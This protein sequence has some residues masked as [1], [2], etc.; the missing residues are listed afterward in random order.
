MSEILILI[1]PFLFSLFIYLILKGETMSK[2]IEEA[3]R[4]IH[5]L[6]HK[7]LY[8][9]DIKRNEAWEEFEKYGVYLDTL[10]HYE[11]TI[12][13]VG[14]AIFNLT[15]YLL[16]KTNETEEDNNEEENEERII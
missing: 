5:A 3:I 9:D 8:G 16:S 13:A 1:I 15:S 14:V 4:E 7:L 11:D 12:D 10:F 2:E 6:S